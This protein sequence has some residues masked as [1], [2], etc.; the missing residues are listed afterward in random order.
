MPTFR[1]RINAFLSP[2]SPATQ[3]RVG[4]AAVTSLNTV[5]A[6][7][8]DSPGWTAQT[9]RPHERDFSEIQSLYE[10]ALTAF[11]K[12]P[13]A[14]RIIQTTTNYILGDRIVVS[15]KRRDLSKFIEAFWN[16]PKNQ[17]DL[18]LAGMSD[19]LARAG[20]LF[21]VLFRNPMDGMSYIRFITK[22]RIIK[23]ES[24]PND[25][26]NELIYYEV[27]DFGEPKPWYS[28]NHPASSEQDAIMLHYAVNRPI[29]ALL[30]ESDLATM[31]PWLQRYSRMLE[32]RVRLHWAV[33][34]FLWIVT[35][36]TNQVQV[37]AEQYRTPPES[38]SIIVK[39]EAEKWEAVAP[40]LNASDAQHDLRAVRGMV[41][42]GSGYPPHW[43]GESSEANLA[44]ATAMQSPTERHLVRRQRYFLFMLQDIL[45][46]SY[47]RAAEIGKARPFT[48]TDYS[49]LFVVAAPDVSRSDNRELSQAA[50]QLAS[51]FASLGAQ[52]GGQ[53][54]AY[55]RL[56]LDLVTRFAGEP[57]SEELLNTIL[58]EAAANPTPQPKQSSTVGGEEKEKEK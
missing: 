4:A 33:R 48:E 35:V 43:R 10:D 19:E 2:P 21:V 52:L 30:G 27:Q 1:D 14:W 37:K 25:W 6:T 44:T 20:D 57:Q 7:V 41:D 18:R 28:P 32:D 12:N 26:E 42:A 39:D 24:A 47:K 46:Q 13:I 45:Y 15:A 22:D 36:P 23:I 3:G 9:G 58:E 38:G 49:N 31:L 5:S 54:P 56:A 29:G 17:L 11:R 8:D 40:N 53:S 16:H 34:A 51:A 50:A 55:T